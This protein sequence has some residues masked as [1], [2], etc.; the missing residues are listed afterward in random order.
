MMLNE[1]SERGGPTGLLLHAIGKN[2]NFVGARSSQ[3]K[4]N[5]MTGDTGNSSHIS[6]VRIPALLRLDLFPRMHPPRRSPKISHVISAAAW[7]S[8]HECRRML[9]RRKSPFDLG[10]TR[11]MVF[12]KAF[13]ECRRVLGEE[14]APC[15]LMAC[16]TNRSAEHPPPSPLPC[17]KHS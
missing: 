17:Y 9:V 16:T 5:G 8:H 2:G 4:I 10:G 6:T 11:S 7:G 15:F 14:S 1:F 12:R 3:S 13:V